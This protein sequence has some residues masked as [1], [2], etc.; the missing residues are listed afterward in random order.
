MADMKSTTWFKCEYPGCPFETDVG[1][2]HQ[3][4][5]Y[6]KECFKKVKKEA[7]NVKTKINK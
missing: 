3:G 4:K 2:E 1:Y 5:Q 6:C 7:S